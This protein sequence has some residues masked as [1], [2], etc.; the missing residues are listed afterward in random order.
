VSFIT[1]CP[2]IA[3]RPFKKPGCKVSTSSIERAN[4][5]MLDAIWAGQHDP[6]WV[7]QHEASVYLY[8]LVGDWRRRCDFSRLF[9]G[10]YISLVVFA[11]EAGDW[12]E[13]VF[14]PIPTTDEAILTLRS[15]Y[16]IATARG[17]M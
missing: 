10:V 2:R 8:N 12:P 6:Q 11:R 13:D 14:G 17:P 5:G 16:P 7:H 4:M 9:R 1:E 15:R 3:S